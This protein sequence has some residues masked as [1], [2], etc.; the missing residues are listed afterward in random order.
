MSRRD[1]E[2]REALTDKERIRKFLTE[3]RNRTEAEK[4]QNKK[5][6]TFE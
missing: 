6:N 1:K 4:I 5:K 3:P 2:V